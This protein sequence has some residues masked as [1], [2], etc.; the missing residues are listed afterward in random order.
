[1]ILF[2][3]DQRAECSA[4]QFDI[5]RS[6]VTIFGSCIQNTA[7]P[8]VAKILESKILPIGKLVTRQFGLEEFGSAIELL[9]QGQ[10]VKAV[11]SP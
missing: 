10:A 2:G 5:T 11:L 4:K 3:M 1:M 8:K 9:R 7:F 6:E